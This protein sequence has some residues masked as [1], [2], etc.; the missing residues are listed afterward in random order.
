[1]RTLLKIDFLLFLASVILLPYALIEN[2]LIFSVITLILLL[3]D[4]YKESDRTNNI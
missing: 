2:I 3:I 4:I 1:M